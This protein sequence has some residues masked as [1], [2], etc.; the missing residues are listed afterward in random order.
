MELLK[1]HHKSIYRE[2]QNHQKFE[3]RIVKL[4]KCNFMLLPELKIN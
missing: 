4:S 1:R 3:R 2:K